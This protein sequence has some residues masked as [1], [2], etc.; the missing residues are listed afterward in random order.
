MVYA[1]YPTAALRDNALTGE[2]GARATAHLADN[3]FA[4]ILSGLSDSD[5]PLLQ[6]LTA[7][8]WSVETSG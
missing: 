7:D 4:V 5:V 8:G 1:E 6:R 3:R 2:R